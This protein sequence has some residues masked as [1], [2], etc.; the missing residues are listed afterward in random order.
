MT[1]APWTRR[2]ISLLGTK[3]DHEVARLTGRSTSAVQEK[4]LFLRIPSLKLWM[5][6]GR[7]PVDPEKVKLLFG[8]Y[9]PPRTRR[10]KFLFCEM[11]GTVKVGNF[12]N[13]P[14]PWPMKWGRRSPILCGDLVR[15][16]QRES[17][18]AVA[19]HWGVCHSV[20]TRWRAAVE[21]G[22]IT[23]GTRR[24]K[25]YVQSEAMTP[26]LRAHMSRVQIGKTR[27]LSRS[28]RARFLAAMRRPKSENWFRSMA[29]LF[30]AR[31]GK[32]VNPE[33]RLWTR[34]EEKLLGKRPDQEVA[35][36]LKRSVS[37]VITRRS[38]KKIPYLNPAL[39]LWTRAEMKLVGKF[40]DA[41]IARRTGHPQ[42]GVRAKRRELGLLFRPPPRRWTRREEQFLGTKPD[43]DIATLLHRGR[44]AVCQRRNALGIPP[45]IKRPPYRKWT[46]REDK[47]LGT[48]SDAQIGR[49]L[50]RSKV[51]VQ[52]R[53][54]RL[55]LPSHREQTLQPRNRLG[56]SNRKSSR[57][58]G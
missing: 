51:S 21:V 15:A 3:P 22:P 41:E 33:H 30:A 53:R 48:A 49:R 19:H 25:S 58:S 46:A 29:P 4:R 5:R 10:G 2:E 42:S 52:L 37:A 18:L 16:V 35:K 12:S 32:L 13:G 28:G 40:S 8:P 31:R 36:L 17:A 1:E 54:L 27:K 43:N 39:R 34:E 44:M 50:R 7:E 56:R 47:L 6:K 11:R 57:V 26:V 24:L 14:I 45:A 20:V 9:S 38:R 23:V 55:D